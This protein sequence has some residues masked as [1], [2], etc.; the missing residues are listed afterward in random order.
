MKNESRLIE[1]ARAELERVKLFDKD[2]F[3]G[4]EL[5]NAVLDLIKLFSTQNHSGNSA[6]IVSRLFNEL[7]SYRPLT[8]LT[9]EPEEWV[10]RGNGF[11]NKRMSSV[12]KDEEHSKAY[13]IDG[14]KFSDDGGES[15]FTNADSFVPVEFPWMPPKEPEKI[16]LKKEEK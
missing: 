13:W 14:K 5:G 2:S 12:F 3:Y 7:A 15:W 16:Y 4:G 9:G 10:D 6:H 11:Q 1:H 8:P